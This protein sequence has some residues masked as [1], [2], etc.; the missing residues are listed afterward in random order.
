MKLLVEKGILL[1]DLRLAI[2]EISLKFSLKRKDWCIP[3]AIVSQSR[4]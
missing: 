2:M 4:L 1:E 3:V